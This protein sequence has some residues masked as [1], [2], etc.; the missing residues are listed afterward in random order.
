LV[1]AVAFSRD[2]KTLVSGSEDKTIKVWDLETGA[3]TLT[4]AGAGRVTSVA[5]NPDM[6][7]FVSGLDNGT[8]EIWQP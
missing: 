6:Q 1:N 2:E 4:L 7:S 5:F 8:V 3:Q